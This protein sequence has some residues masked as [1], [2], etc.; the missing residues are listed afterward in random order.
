[1]YV[2]YCG[3]T[4]VQ[5]VRYACTCDVD[6]IGFVMYP[7][8]ARSVDVATVKRLSADV[9]DHIDR[10]AVTVNMPLCM[11]QQLVKQTRINTLQLHGDESTTYIQKLRELLPHIQIFKALKG[12]DTIAQQ[13]AKYAPYVDRLLIDTPSHAYGGVGA[14]FDWRLLESIP[15]EKV[16]IAGGLNAEMLPILLSQ[17]PNIAGVDIASGIEDETKGQKSPN[18]MTT[19]QHILGGIYHDKDTITCR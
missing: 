15:L 11:I 14:T 5:D 17:R 10:V 6:A 18:K 9:P 8:S 2:K 7:P 16:L 13:V 4:R 19:I 12:D 1:M 3:F